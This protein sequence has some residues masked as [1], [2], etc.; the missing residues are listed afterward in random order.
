MD[1]VKSTFTETLQKGLI[2]RGIQLAEIKDPPDVIYVSPFFI[3]QLIDKPV[4]KSATNEETVPV[5]LFAESVE[6]R[7]LEQVV[8]ETL[9]CA[10]L[11]TSCL[12]NV[13][14]INWLQCYVD[15]LLT[16]ANLQETYSG[17]LFK[18]GAGDMYQSLKEVNIP[19]SIDGLDVP[20]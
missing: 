7:F 10:L 2:V 4:I 11:D 14:G 3:G 13:C 5:Q 16:D 17:K 20:I 8:S 1:A 19:V 15:S 6:Q 12:A 18:F 9:N